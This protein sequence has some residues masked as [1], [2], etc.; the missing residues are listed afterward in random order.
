[1][2]MELKAI[3]LD[4]D[5]TLL[6]F[7]AAAQQSMEESFHK[8]GLSFHPAMMSI[9]NEENDKIWQRIEKKELSIA[10][11][12][13]V[14]WQT[15][16]PKLGLQADGEAMEKEFKSRL[17]TSAVPVEGA[18]E[19]LSYLHKKYMLCAASNGPYR[20]QLNRLEKA[21]MLGYFTH[22]FVSEQMGVEKPS[23]RFFDGCF[24]ELP[25]ILP[26]ETMM[27]G[28]SLTAD[29]AGGRQAGMHTCWYDRKQKSTS[30]VLIPG[31]E[32]VDDTILDLLELKEL[33]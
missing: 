15:I 13:H 8:F 9:F 2:I 20:Q 23:Q 4:I 14:R 26:E 5:N 24:T 10:D 17:H 3:F 29:M 33:L 18:I 22:C 6:D 7:D 32:Y 11:L 16:L 30:G 25:G 28:D 12:P 19:I 21:G 31:M 27:I 1:M